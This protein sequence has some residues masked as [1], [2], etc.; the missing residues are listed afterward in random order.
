MSKFC[1]RCG[2]Q[3]D[4]NAIFCTKCG[5]NLGQPNQQFN[6][7]AVKNVAAKNT[8][9][10]AVKNG[11]KKTLAIVGGIVGAVV[12]LIVVFICC[13]IFGGGYKDPLKR[14]KK[15]LENGD[16][17]SYRQ[18]VMSDKYFKAIN[19]NNDAVDDYFK[20]DIDEYYDY[21][22]LWA[23]LE[24]MYGKNIKVT[25][26]IKT[27]KK[28]KKSDLEDYQDDL[29]RDADSMGIDDYEPKVTAGYELKI[30]LS[31]KGDDDKYTDTNSLH[32]YKVDGDWV[33]PSIDFWL[34]YYN[35]LV[36]GSGLVYGG[37]I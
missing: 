5:A 8:V 16:G 9:T 34:L 33:I 24:D 11:D 28:L 19:N 30:N 27:K 36:Y 15:T 25:Y 7:D 14:M 3:L 32:V 18:M 29:Q 17:K 1:G 12:V 35:N 37:K 21:D 23:P 2:A 13:L 6:A 4:D 26:D 22:R 31:V 20:G 10:A